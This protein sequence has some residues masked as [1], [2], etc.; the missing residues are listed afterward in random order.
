VYCG[1]EAGVHTNA[2]HYWKVMSSYCE[3]N[4]WP[5]FQLHI[6]LWAEEHDIIFA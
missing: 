6:D 4:I 5:V 1:R 2:L 3:L